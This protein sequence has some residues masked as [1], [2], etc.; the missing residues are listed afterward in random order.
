ML[1]AALDS[2]PTAE[3]LVSEQV[4]RDYVEQFD[5]QF[6][7]FCEKELNKINTFFAEK[8]A[9]AIRKISDL[10]NELNNVLPGS[11]NDEH[12]HMQVLKANSN[13]NRSKKTKQSH[14][15]AKKISDL[16]LAFSEFY[17]NLVLLQNYQ[18]LNFTGFR[19][20]LKK[21]DKLLSTNSGNLWRQEKVDESRFYVCKEV[22]K[23][24][25]ETENI[26]TNVLEDGN[27]SRAMKRLR[28]PPLNA[29]QSLWT[30][31]RVGL[32]SGAFCILFL[33]LI[34]S[35]KFFLTNPVTV[36]ESN[37]CFLVVHFRES[38]DTSM[39]MKLF[40]AP[41]LVCVF[42]FLIGVNVYGWRTSGVNHVLIFELDPRDH[43]SEQHLF[44]ISFMFF[45][46]WS[47]SMLGFI[48]S[49]IMKLNPNL[50][51]LVNVILFLI[52]LFN[53]TKTLNYS[54]R[55]WL[56]RVLVCFLFK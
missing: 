9:E 34:L 20:I 35:C 33:I 31:F 48:Y 23:L 17:L 15:V 30:T 32:F 53:P 24:I 29:H 21:H 4:Y 6:F 43:I 16:K 41:F 5:Q 45:V 13:G 22:D 25:D 10:K 11:S 27:R 1:Y 8:L 7:H 49:P 39:M 54:A 51:P 46:I 42:L 12:F 38:T 50:F 40:R 18:T 14:K 47:L 56:I 52:F 28:V 3:L 26:F 44:E 2:L 37:F 36:I 55:Y 19:K